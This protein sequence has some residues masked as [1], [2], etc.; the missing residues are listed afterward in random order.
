MSEAAGTALEL[1]DAKTISIE[2]LAWMCVVLAKLQSW[3]E[4]IRK[5]N[6]YGAPLAPEAEQRLHDCTARLEGNAHLLEQILSILD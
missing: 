5:V 4:R 2:G 6:F 3:L 1:M